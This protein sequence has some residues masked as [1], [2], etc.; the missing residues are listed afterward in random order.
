MHHLIGCSETSVRVKAYG[1]KMVVKQ[2]S[3]ELVVLERFWRV[4]AGVKC[5]VLE[6]VRIPHGSGRGN[7]PLLLLA[8]WMVHLMSVA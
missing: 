6:F 2:L 1:Q 3:T 4:C 5:W 7:C 8:F